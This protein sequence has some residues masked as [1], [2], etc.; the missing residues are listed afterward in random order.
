MCPLE[1]SSEVTR[2]VFRNNF[3]LD[4]DTDTGFVPLCLFRQGTSAD[5]QH[6][7]HERTHDL[8]LR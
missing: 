2:V 4:R 8:D 3:W 1:R 7:L 5:M 6:E